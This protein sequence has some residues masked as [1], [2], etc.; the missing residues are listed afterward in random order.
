MHVKSLSIVLAEF[1][2]LVNQSA[3]NIYVCAFT[4]IELYIDARD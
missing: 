4:Q 2:N 3:H 1:S